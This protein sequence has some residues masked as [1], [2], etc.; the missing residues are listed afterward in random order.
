MTTGLKS[1]RFFGGTGAYYT[2]A[3]VVALLYGLWDFEWNPARGLGRSAGILIVAG[4]FTGGYWLLEHRS[5]QPITR[6]RIARAYFWISVI[7]TLIAMPM[8]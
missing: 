3:G 7:V 1:K 4:F 2:G 6:L 8:H 5:Q